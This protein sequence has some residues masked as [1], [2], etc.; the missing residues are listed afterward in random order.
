MK[1]LNLEFPLCQTSEADKIYLHIQ[2]N[3][4]FSQSGSLMAEPRTIKQ[5]MCATLSHYLRFKILNTQCI[6]HTKIGLESQND[7]N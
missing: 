7:L 3:V 4:W 6:P 2:G 1:I 5:G